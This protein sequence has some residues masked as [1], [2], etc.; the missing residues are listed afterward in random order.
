MK[1]H[2]IREDQEKVLLDFG[3]TLEDIQDL[4]NTWWNRGISDSVIE[5]LLQITVDASK[6]VKEEETLIKN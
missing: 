1:I 3:F 2:I 4:C 6:R 5:E